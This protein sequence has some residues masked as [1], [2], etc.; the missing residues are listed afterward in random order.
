[1]PKITVTVTLTATI[2]LPPSELGVGASSLESASVKAEND[3]A[4]LLAAEVSK[5]TPNR[6][7]VTMNVEVDVSAVPPDGPPPPPG[8]DSAES[9]EDSLTCNEVP[10]YK[11]VDSGALVLF[12]DQKR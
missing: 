10:L 5:Q 8:V 4:S 6:K 9:R 2:T 7:N 12:A 3:L 11:D 1:M